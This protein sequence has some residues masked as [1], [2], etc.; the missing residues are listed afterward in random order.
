MAQECYGIQDVNTGLWLI[1]W[2]PFSQ[3]GDFGNES[4]AICFATEADRDEV[5]VLLNANQPGG[6]VGGRP[7]KPPK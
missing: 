5:L 7:N 3:T 6:F 2:N 1:S 4:S